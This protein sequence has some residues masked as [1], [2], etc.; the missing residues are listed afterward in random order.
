MSHPF[1]EGKNEYS[2]YFDENGSEK[3]LKIGGV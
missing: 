1:P 3:P 2:A